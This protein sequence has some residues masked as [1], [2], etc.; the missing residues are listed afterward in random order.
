MSIKG[1]LQDVDLKLFIKFINKWFWRINAKLDGI[2]SLANSKSSRRWVIEDEED[3]N[4]YMEETSSQW[5]K[6]AILKRDGNLGNIK[7]SI[8]AFQGKNDPKLYL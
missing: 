2:Q 5:G 7:M 1:E 6:K 8:L 3:E 4:S